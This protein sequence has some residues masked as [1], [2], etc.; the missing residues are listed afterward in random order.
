MAAAARALRR[1]FAVLRPISALV[2]ALEA[3]LQ[4]SSVDVRNV[5]ELED[6]RLVDL[7]QQRWYAGSNSREK[8][9]P[10][11][12]AIATEM[13]K[14]AAACRNQ[15]AHHGEAIRV[16]EQGRTFL[17][18]EGA[19]AATATGRVLLILAT[20]YA[21]RARLTDAVET[22]QVVSDLE[23]A[24]LEVRV[25]ALEAL[26]GLCLRLQQEE[27]ALRYAHSCGQLVAAA[28]ES[29]PE[30][31]LA[32]LKF[33]GKAV[34]ALA[35]LVCAQCGAADSRLFQD[36]P[37]WL[38]ENSR[39]TA[40][41]AAA[42]LSIAECAHVG[43]AL[44][45]AGEI[46][47]K[48]IAII[49]NSKDASETTYASVAMHPDEVHVGALAGLGQL[50]THKGDLEEAEGKI[51]EALSLAEKIN[52][53]RHARVGIILACLADVYARRGIT[54]GSGDSFII[55]EGLYRRCQDYLG[56]PS[57]D[58]PD[59]GKL[60]D[61]V[62]VMALSRA[63]YADIV[64]KFPNRDEEAEKVKKWA[65]MHWKGP[66]PLQNLMKVDGAQKA[67]AKEGYV[68]IDVRLGRV[69]FKV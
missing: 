24:G 66:R 1:S 20:F 51:T 40:G 18:N 17:L 28:G 3:L 49:R 30:E 65:N 50:A 41:V 15:E 67:S 9:K 44:E 23:P 63:R 27:P 6:A 36:V 29:V 45:L 8:P 60:V 47:K 14:Y 31:M 34:T 48:T 19:S 4:R 62:D 16:L 52:G 25:A 61:L 37:T 13:I 69:I 54:K 33:R 10:D 5:C 53:D 26:A 43:G 22:L 7:R 59:T 11:V 42:M 56:S 12:D 68:V 32:E 58:V 21:D 57:V 35:A 38:G 64:A 39:R 55:A 2:P 46:Y